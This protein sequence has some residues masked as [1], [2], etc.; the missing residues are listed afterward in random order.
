M[1]VSLSLGNVQL[2]GTGLPQTCIVTPIVVLRH[3]DTYLCGT[4]S[5]SA[6]TRQEPGGRTGPGVCGISTLALTVN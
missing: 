2:L 4:V 3:A 1:G 5:N 6:I